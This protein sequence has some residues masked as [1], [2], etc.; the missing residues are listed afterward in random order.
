[1]QQKQEVEASSVLICIRVL[2]INEDER[3]NYELISLSL[4]IV[5]GHKIT[6]QRA[7]QR[8]SLFRCN[9]TRKIDQ[10]GAS[11]VDAWLRL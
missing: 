9:D 10:E 6:M 5:E 8:G 1:M 4:W 2:P 11:R 7:Y 3:Q